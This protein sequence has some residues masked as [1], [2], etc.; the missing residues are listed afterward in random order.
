MMRLIYKLN[1]KKNFCMTNISVDVVFSGTKQMN[2]VFIA[3]FAMW[4]LLI[5]CIDIF[6]VLCV[7]CLTT[8]ISV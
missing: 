5:T 8:F 7:N 3:L 2:Y 4:L 1:E 6:S